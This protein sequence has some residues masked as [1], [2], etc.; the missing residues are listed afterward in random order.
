[1][2]AKRI[3][4]LNVNTGDDGESIASLNVNTGDDGEADCVNDKEETLDAGRHHDPVPHDDG[5]FI[6]RENGRSLIVDPSGWDSLIRRSEKIS[7]GRICLLLTLR[8]VVE[9]NDKT[10][11]GGANLKIISIWI[12]N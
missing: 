2:M 9:L 3:A 8:Q 10:L 4:S 7:V 6:F 1:M 11:V 5:S 12:K